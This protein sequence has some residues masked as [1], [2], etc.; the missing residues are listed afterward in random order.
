MPALFRLWQCRNK[1]NRQKFL[2]SLEHTFLRDTITN[3]Q[4]HKHRM[5]YARQ[6]IGRKITRSVG[7]GRSPGSVG[8]EVGVVMF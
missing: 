3:K 2:P 6:G 8:W 1:N 5:G 4:T 7:Q